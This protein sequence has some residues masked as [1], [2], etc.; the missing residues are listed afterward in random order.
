MP[1]FYDKKAKKSVVKVIS[2]YTSVK[3]FAKSFKWCLAYM[4]FSPSVSFAHIYTNTIYIAYIVY[5]AIYN[6]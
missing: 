5:L 1:N 3:L 2:I 4:I 6:R